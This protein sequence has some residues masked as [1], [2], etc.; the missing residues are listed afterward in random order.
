MVKMQ[1]IILINGSHPDYLLKLRG[2][3]IRKL[4]S[5]GYSVH[6]STPGLDD[7]AL[8]NI[9]D[10]GAVAHAVSVSRRKL[11]PFSDLSYL[12]EMWQLIRDLKPHFVINYTIKPNIWA[13]FAARLTKVRY[14]FM[15]TGLGYAF[16]PSNNK[17]RSILQKTVH[18][19]YRIASAGAYAVLFQNPDDVEDFRQAGCLPDQTKAKI[20]N[21]SGVDVNHFYDC[22]LPQDDSYLLIS[23]L[24]STKGVR[25]YVEAG[26]KLKAESPEVKI[27]LA[28]FL[29]FGPDA[30]SEEELHGWI[31]RG[32]EFLGKLEDIRPAMEATAVYVLPSYREGT[33]RTV[34]EAMSMGRPIISTDAPGCRETVVHQQNGMLVPVAD[35]D[36]LYRSMKQLQ[37][38]H[39]LKEAYGRKSRSIALE[40]Y[41]VERVNEATTEYFGL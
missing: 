33:P 12:L 22:A 18:K 38:N 28:G 20:T 3:L 36:A 40:K 14:G 19:L 24:L 34:L 29:D 30:I 10:L 15:V 4:I 6:V 21:G 26:L 25:E 8:E 17:I 31:A 39:E 41:A 7:S 35:Q 9:A 11:N 16:I 23:R 32:V 5:M 27:R 1:K 2:D 13:S 37:G